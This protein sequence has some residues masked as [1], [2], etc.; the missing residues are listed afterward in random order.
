MKNDKEVKDNIVEL[1][2]IK[3]ST[4][5]FN[6]VFNTINHFIKY[7]C[8]VFCFHVIFEGLKPFLSSSPEVI[9]AMAKVIESINFSNIT[10]YLISGALG[11][12]WYYERRGKKR[13]INQ[14][15]KYQ[16]MAER[17]DE[18]RSSSGLTKS[19]DTP[20]GEIND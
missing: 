20:K 2:K 10:S 17:N 15:G 6:T 18:Y 9:N 7:G 4:D 19:G 1:E 12:G 14:K 16:K 11:V 3:S 8:I 5:K 13:A